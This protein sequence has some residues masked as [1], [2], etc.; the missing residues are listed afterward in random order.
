MVE[1]EADDESDEEDLTAI[2]IQVITERCAATSMA[3]AL[4]LALTLALILAL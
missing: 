4:A 2:E 1:F 3:L